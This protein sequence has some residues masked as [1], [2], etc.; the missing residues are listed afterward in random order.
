MRLATLSRLSGRL[1]EGDSLVASL[2]RFVLTTS[3]H[4]VYEQSMP[5]L[6][7]C[8]SNVFAREIVSAGRSSCLSFPFASAGLISVRSLNFRQ[9]TAMVHRVLEQLC[10]R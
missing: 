9:C 1:W 10:L 3:R 4:G 7:T 5:S 6:E 2:I 8:V